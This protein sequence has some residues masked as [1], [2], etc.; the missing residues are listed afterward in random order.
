MTNNVLYLYARMLSRNDLEY[1]G[2]VFDIIS[3]V[4][5]HSALE[6][7]THYKLTDEP[8]PRRI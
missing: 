8:R 2:L 7:W 4:C 3:D 6:F 1:C 5:V